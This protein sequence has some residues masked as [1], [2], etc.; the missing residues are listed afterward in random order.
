MLLDY[1][2]GPWLAAVDAELAARDRLRAVAAHCEV[3]LTQVITGAGEPLVYH[4]TSHGGE[5]RAA[6]GPADPEDVRITEDRDTALAIAA[7][8][9]NAKEAFITG[10]VTIT[11][12]RQRLIVAHQVLAA[13]DEVMAVVADRTRF[14]DA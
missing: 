5:A 13:L 4:V 8:R 7:G 12:D 9:R 10:Q 14:T 3:G 2:S 6:W 1:L 11:G